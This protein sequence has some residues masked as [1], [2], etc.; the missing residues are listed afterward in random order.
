MDDIR[1]NQQLAEPKRGINLRGVLEVFM[2]WGALALLILK[3]A[4]RSLWQTMRTTRVSYLPLAF[5]AT[6][7]VNWLMA[8]RWGLILGVR[9]HRLKT[10]RLFFYYLI[11]IFFMNFVPG[12]GISGD[13]A[14]LLYADREVRDKPFVLSSLIY[15]RLVGLFTLLLL[16]LG[17]TDFSHGSLPDR[18]AFYLGEAA[19]AVALL[20]STALM[21]GA[22]SARLGRLILWLSRRVKMERLG[23]AAVRTLE[24]IADFR[25]HKRML[26]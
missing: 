6:L 8:Y 20:A 12:G 21:S 22:L 23:A 25:K 5:L 7:C 14:R 1:T 16:G 26:G 4:T 2:G 15:E 18:R 11:G 9:G 17:A 10:Y 13:V 19:L 3:S 24:A